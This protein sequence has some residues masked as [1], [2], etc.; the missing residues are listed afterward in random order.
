MTP[1]NNTCN[2]NFIYNNLEY[3]DNKNKLNGW[4]YLLL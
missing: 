1:R 4:G 3:K 2:I